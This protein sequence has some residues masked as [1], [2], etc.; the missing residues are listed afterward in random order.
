MLSQFIFH[1]Y[2]QYDSYK[3]SGSKSDANRYGIDES[4][5]MY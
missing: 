5:V 1:V 3:G 2:V 4:R